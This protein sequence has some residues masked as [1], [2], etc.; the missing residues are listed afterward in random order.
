[1]EGTSFLYT[2][3]DASAPERHETQYFEMMGNRGIYHKGW[4]AATMHRTPWVVTGAARPFDEDVWELY[5]EGDWTQARDV[6]SENPDKLRELQRMWLIEAARYGV[7]PMDDRMVERADAAVSGRPTLIRG[8]TQTLYEGMQRLTENSVLNIKNRSHSVTAQ[9]DV[10]DRAAEGVIIA[11]GGGTGG[12]TL[13][14]KGGRLKYCY[15]FLGLQHFYAE[16]KAPIPAGQHLVRMEFAYD[17]GGLGK[18]GKVTLLVDGKTVGTGAVAVTQAI[19]FS[20]DETC[21]VGRDAGSPTSPD[22]RARDNAFNGR[23]KWV[24][25]D[26]EGN[27]LESP[28]AVEQNLK[29]AKAAMARQ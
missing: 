22:Y 2:F 11:Q 18:G 24:K 12:W 28:A 16:A 8:R 27:E 1:M 3:G 4:T 6:A 29:T 5:A 14:A 23:V 9:V 26:V 17:G 20:A 15:N 21:D 25:I 7:L 10:G 13:Y 19:L